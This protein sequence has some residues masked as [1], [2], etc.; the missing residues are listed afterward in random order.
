MKS[1][2]P[3]LLCAALA[4][5]CSKADE[6]A[7]EPAGKSPKQAP[8]TTA[9]RVEVATL[10]ASQP[11][12]RV[13]RP[14]EI[15]GARQARLASS[16][17]GFVER[18]MVEDGQT[19]K[20][21]ATIAHIDTSVHN[22][23]AALTRVEVDD[24]VRELER[25]ESLG[26][27]V[28]SAR[29][30]AART[31]VSRARAQ[32]ALSRTRQAR[33]VIRAPFAGVIVD[34]TMERGEVAAPGA[35]IARLIQLEPVLVSVSVTDRDVQSLVTGGTAT[36]TAAGSSE[37]LAGTIH[38]IVPAADERTRSFLIEVMVTGSGG[39][40]LPG[41]IAE[42]A[43]ERSFTE[44]GLLIPQDF[45]VTRL[46]G[47]GVFVVDAN[48]VARW[49]PLKLG[50]VVGSQVAVTDGLAVGETI[51]V[52]GH[53]DL[54]DGDRLIVT[55]HGTCCVDGRVTHARAASAGGAR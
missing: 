21:G 1:S 11:V 34:L 22:A 4:A 53:R 15:Q 7:G 50:Q 54:A 8:S 29:V 25:L 12:L 55:R 47:N 40:L 26:K 51:V 45:L 32:H 28:A 3:I 9:V 33:A 23:Q 6:S 35:T 39:K 31:Q 14:G 16:L 38:R 48:E 27:A 20:K 36:V 2:L 19:V 24:A 18:V 52:L 41:M 17:G 5:S 49:R 42:V 30:D 46:D 43:F 37:V 10:D 44:G 13:V